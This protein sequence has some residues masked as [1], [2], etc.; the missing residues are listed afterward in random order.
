MKLLRW[1]SYLKKD[2]YKTSREGFL[3]F[4]QTKGKFNK[5]LRKNFSHVFLIQ[6]NSEGIYFLFDPTRFLPINSAHFVEDENDMKLAVKKIY[7]TATILKYK[8]NYT[9]SRLSFLFCLPRIFSCVTL[10][11]Y[12]AGIP[13]FCL[14]PYQFYKKLKNKDFIKE[15]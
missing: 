9:Y 6:H 10:V 11:Q 14:T 15:V 13:M 3:V 8:L 7:P 1:L 12:M 2:K 5:I 4:C